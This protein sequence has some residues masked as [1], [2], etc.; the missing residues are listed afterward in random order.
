MR[1]SWRRGRG[2]VGEEVFGG[3]EGEAKEGKVVG[4]VG[5]G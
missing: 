1:E 3:G 5:R 4:G 2:G